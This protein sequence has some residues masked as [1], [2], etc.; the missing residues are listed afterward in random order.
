MGKLVFARGNAGVVAIVASDHLNSIDAPDLIL[1]G[2]GALLSK[3]AQEKHCEEWKGR[4]ELHH[5]DLSSF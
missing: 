4:W 3:D 1:N 2:W 5:L